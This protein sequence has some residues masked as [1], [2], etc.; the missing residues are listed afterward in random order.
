LRPSTAAELPA[1][2]QKPAV[3]NDGRLFYALPD[4]AK[5]LPQAKIVVA[6]LNPAI[7]YAAAYRFY[8]YVLGILG[9]PVCGAMT[10]VFVRA[11]RFPI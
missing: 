2:R 9:R 3:A 6:R 5:H 8:R 10:A 7:E 1:Y 4:S 11:R